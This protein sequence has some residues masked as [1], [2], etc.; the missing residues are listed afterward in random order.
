[1]FGVKR[2]ERGVSRLSSAEVKGTTPSGAEVMSLYADGK[3]DVAVIESVLKG[4]PLGL[5]EFAPPRYEHQRD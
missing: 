3:R 1:M 2:S 5:I 4:Y